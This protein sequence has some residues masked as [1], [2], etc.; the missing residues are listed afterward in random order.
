MISDLRTVGQLSFALCQ[1]GMVFLIFFWM[2]GIIECF[3]PD[4]TSS[5]TKPKG[6]SHFSYFVSRSQVPSTVKNRNN[7]S[8]VVVVVIVK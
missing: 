4:G 8:L 3:V 7:R 2:V 6:G 1:S 5:V